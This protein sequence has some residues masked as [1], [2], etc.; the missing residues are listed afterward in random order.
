M[1]EPTLIDRIVA[2]AYLL[3]FLFQPLGF[4]GLFGVGAIL[5]PRRGLD[6]WVLGLWLGA[7]AWLLLWAAFRWWA[8]RW[9]RRRWPT[10]DPEPQS[11]SPQRE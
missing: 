7:A 4:F 9:G 6:R 3:A 11:R 1:R 8:P 2:V 5:W 10:T